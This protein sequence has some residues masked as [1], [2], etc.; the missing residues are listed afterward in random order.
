MKIY[1]IGIGM[2]DN[3]TLTAEAVTAMDCA[4][5]FIGAERMLEAVSGCNKPVYKEY[6]ADKIK[7]YLDLHPEYENAAILL[8]GDISFYSGAKK[9]SMLLNGADVNF[10]AKCTKL[11]LSH[12]QEIKSSLKN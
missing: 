8:S 7:E 11:P 12:V 9:L 4:D 6:S 1:L 5:V 2:G 3:K 10:T